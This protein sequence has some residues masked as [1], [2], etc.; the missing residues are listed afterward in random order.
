MR[1]AKPPDFLAIGKGRVR[2]TR[3]GQRDNEK[4]RERKEIE[5]ETR[6]ERRRH[7]HGQ[8]GRMDRDLDPGRRGDAKEER[9]R[10][11]R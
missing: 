3:E 1:F 9:R 11:K 7:R 4:E 8:I 2:D 10:E 5:R 6:G